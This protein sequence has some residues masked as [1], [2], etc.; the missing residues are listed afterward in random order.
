MLAPITY[1]QPLATIRRPRMLSVEGEVLVSEGDQVHSGDVIARANLAAEHMMLDATRALGLNPERASKMIQRSVGEKVDQGAIIAGRRGVG[2][3]Q[4]RAP[5]KGTIAAISEGQI[6]LQVSDERAELHARVPG[7]VIDVEAGRGVVIECVCAWVQGVWGNG[8]VADGILHLVGDGPE[9]ILTAD[10]ID[11]SLRGAILLAGHCGQKQAL[12][13]AA[14]VPIRGLIL[15]SL[16]TRLLPIAEKVPYPILVTEG[17]GTAAMN[18]DA[19]MLFSNHKQA[20]TT[21]NAQRT[22]SIT[23][24]RPEVIIPLKDAGRPP[25]PVELQTFRV[26]QNV[27]L[28]NGSYKGQLGEIVSLLPASTL[29][30]SGLRAVGAEVELASGHATTIPLA[31]LELLG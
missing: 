23:G 7:E 1:I 2:A 24:D 6:L 22:D 18:A 10:Q 4:L 11:M 21:L 17:F 31:N 27:R 20:Q 8:R 15:G 13:L 26:G 25:Q 12:E 5:A 16:T 9:Q 3:R 28:L 19:F 14:Q 29:F 30:P